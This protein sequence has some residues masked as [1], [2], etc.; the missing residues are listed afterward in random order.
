MKNLSIY[1]CVYCSSQHLYKVSAT[2][3]KCV[4][5]RKKFSAKKVQFDLQVIATFC[6]GINAQ[7]AS[8]IL[9][10]NYKTVQSRY[11]DFRLL[12]TNFLEQQY[13]NRK[14]EFD[15]Y[16]EYYYLDANKR[17]NITYISDAI[18]ILGMSYGTNIYTLLLQNPFAYAKNDHTI[19]PLTLIEYA[20]YFNRYK[21]IHYEKF[22]NILVRFWLH[23]EKS[24]RQFKGVSYKNFIFYLKECEFS[25]NFERQKREQI[26]K[27][28]W[29][30]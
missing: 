4:T 16:E 10:V 11:K 12:I 20:K 29:F 1:K 13:Q 24:M 25:F 18:C 14:E 9:G 3:Y 6:D 27:E 21:I 22:D 19:D 15:E 5:C 17:T 28:L 30:V 26:L 23:V 8:Q 2:Q 7:K